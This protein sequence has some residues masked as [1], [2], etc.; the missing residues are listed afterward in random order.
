LQAQENAQVGDKA[1][2]TKIA[3]VDWRLVY[4]AQLHG[5]TPKV[6]ALFVG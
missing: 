6:H 5:K 4:D 3:F 1:F 2:A